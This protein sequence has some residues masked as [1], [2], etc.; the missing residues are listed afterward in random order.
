[1]LL[2]QTRS[3]NNPDEK[4]EN[5]RRKLFDCPSWLL[6]SWWHWLLLMSRLYDLSDALYDRFMQLGGIEY[7]EESISY[8]RQ[9]ER[10]NRCPIGDRNRSITLNQLGNALIARFMHLG[11]NN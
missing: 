1:M 5:C 11:H 10:F 4:V 9:L 3:N 2:S 7:L 8:Y 6:D